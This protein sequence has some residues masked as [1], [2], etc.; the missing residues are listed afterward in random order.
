MLSRIALYRLHNTY[1]MVRQYPCNIIFTPSR[2]VSRVRRENS[3]KIPR[4]RAIKRCRVGDFGGYVCGKIARV[5]DN[6]RRR[7]IGAYYGRIR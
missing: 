1:K 6:L 5:R 2:K 4:G 7:I 3:V